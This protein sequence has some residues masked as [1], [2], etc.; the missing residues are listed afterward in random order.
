MDSGSLGCWVF[1]VPYI[2]DP[3]LDDGHFRVLWTMET[4]MKMMMVIV[5]T[6]V[7]MMMMVMVMVIAISDS[8]GD[9]GGGG[10]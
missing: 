4:V 1:S 9:G 2:L 8:D 5:M 7:M 10:S 6:M 3:G